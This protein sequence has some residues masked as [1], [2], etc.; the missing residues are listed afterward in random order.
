MLVR[1]TRRGERV[2]VGRVEREL[3]RLVA[4]ALA[5]LPEERVQLGRVGRALRSAAAEFVPGGEGSKC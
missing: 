1:G 2:E 3:L 4:R 5:L